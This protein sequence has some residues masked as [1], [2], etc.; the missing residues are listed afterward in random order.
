[1]FPITHFQITKK[2]TLDEGWW[3]A[4]NLNGQIGLIPTNF[5]DLKNPVPVVKTE[6]SDFAKKRDLIGGSVAVRPKQEKTAQFRKDIVSMPPTA[7]EDK[8]TGKPKQ[9]CVLFEIL[10]L[11]SLILSLI[12]LP[13]ILCLMKIHNH[14]NL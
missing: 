7:F 12:L 10:N 1:M 3:E 8:P 2:D 5:L 14:K 6:S 9:V 13:E 4:K 11:G